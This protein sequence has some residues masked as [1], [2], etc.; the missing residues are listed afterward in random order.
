MLSLAEAVESGIIGLLLSTIGTYLYARRKGAESLDAE[1]REK[2]RSLAHE[3]DEI[4]AAYL[5]LQEELL[6]KQK[7]YSP[8]DEQL[9]H[10]ALH[11]FGRRVW[12][13]FQH[14]L[15]CDDESEQELISKFKKPDRASIA[16]WI[17]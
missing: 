10:R 11:L 2:H 14:L 6:P 4:Q 1:L 3:Y 5:T 12:P 15:G 17:H 13:V 8:E 7:S 9:V 16:S